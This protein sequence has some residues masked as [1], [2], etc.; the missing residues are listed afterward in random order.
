[1]AP[2]TPAAFNCA[3]CLER[4]NG[5][6]HRIDRKPVCRPCIAEH[7]LPKYRAAVE[8]EYRHPT[9]WSG[10]AEQVPE[11]LF[12]QY[13]RDAF[14]EK[15]E[16][17]PVCGSCGDPE[18]D[19]RHCREDFSAYQDEKE[20]SKLLTNSCGDSEHNA[21]GHDDD[22][23]TQP[24]EEAMNDLPEQLQCPKCGAQLG[25]YKGCDL[26]TCGKPCLGFGA[27]DDLAK[28]YDEPEDGFNDKG[29]QG[30]FGDEVAR[31]SRRHIGRAARQAL[32][33]VRERADHGRVDSGWDAGCGRA[34]RRSAGQ[35]R[36]YHDR[37][38][39]RTTALGD[40]LG[41]GSTGG[42]GGEPRG[43]ALDVRAKRA[44]GDEQRAYGGEG[45]WDRFRAGVDGAIRGV[46]SIVNE[47]LQSRLER[48][49]RTV[50]DSGETKYD[51]GRARHPKARN[52]VLE[53]R[54]ECEDWD[55]DSKDCE[56]D[57]E[58]DYSKGSVRGAGIKMRKALVK[59]F[60]ARLND[61]ML[62]H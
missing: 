47:A 43:R 24:E 39:K 9:G 55:T 22:W 26:V 16:R 48:E 52:R 17:G 37:A 57:D 60:G 4:R 40:D 45:P 5:I 36:T 27:P 13:L 41:Q 10:E 61:W 30:T 51:G 35:E 50:F 42:Y 58:S 31:L 19:A 18:H 54:R 38:P 33:Y 2:T 34:Y 49:R 46:E 6:P 29:V 32:A 14:Y 53:A 12:S 1:M 15:W 44:F 8:S 28:G 7:I 11:A 56:S 25:Q 3:L 62:D 59:G 20:P 21:K 23:S